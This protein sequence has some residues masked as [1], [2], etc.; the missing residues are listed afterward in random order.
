MERYFWPMLILRWYLTFHDSATFAP[1]PAIF[2]LADASSFDVAVCR[3][4]DEHAVSQ[5]GVSGT[6]EL[7]A[8]IAI[9]LWPGVIR[10]V[11]LT[12]LRVCRGA[13][14]SVT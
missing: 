1:D 10:A 5:A 11:G 3:T 14:A 13:L 8:H 4:D 2:G 9:G 7:P 6:V 12:D